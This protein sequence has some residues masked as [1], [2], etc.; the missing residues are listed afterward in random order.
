[1]IRFVRSATIKPG[2]VP[3]AMA[4]ASEVSELVERKT[5]VPVDVFVQFGGPVGRISWTGDIG[6]LGQYEEAVGVLMSD[7]D[8]LAKIGEAAGLFVEGQTTESLWKKR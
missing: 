3:A 1:M 4:F 8:Y 7:S 6:D 2:Q 5:G